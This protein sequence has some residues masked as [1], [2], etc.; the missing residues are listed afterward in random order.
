MEA[1]LANRQWCIDNRMY[2]ANLWGVGPSHGPADGGGTFYG[3]YGAPPDNLPFQKGIDNDGTISPSATLP[4]IVFAP[5]EVI[6]V[7]RF[8]YDTYKERFWK[9][10][11]FPDALNPAREWF[12]KEYIA[13]D[14]GPI[15]INIENYR[16]RLMY[17]LF[18]QEPIVWNGLRRAGFMGIVDNF[19]PSE[20][21]PAYGTW[22]ASGTG[23]LFRL[24][25]SRDRVKEGQHALKVRWTEPGPSSKPFLAVRPGRTDFSPYNFLTFWM[26]GDDGLKPA[27]LLQGG[28]PFPLKEVTRRNLA[29]GWNRL[30]FEIP[31]EARTATVKE[32][33]FL[34]TNASP[35]VCWLDGI[36]LTHE[37]PPSEPDFVID[38]FAVTRATWSSGSA[39]HAT[40]ATNASPSSASSLRIDYQKT[41][42]ADRDAIISVKPGITDWSRF[43]SVTMWARGSGTL[44]LRLADGAGRSF[45]VGTATLSAAKG[46]KMLFF[47]I[48]ANLNPDNCW[49]P[50]YDKRDI[51]EMQLMM[52]PGKTDCRGTVCLGPLLL[53]E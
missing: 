5:Q 6:R 28:K 21:S 38:D 15:V 1:T 41:G 2:D 50:R 7:A 25:K 8:I 32:L 19:N 34:L 11:G 45:D 10:Y 47:N 36:F 4:S 33:R 37:I 13:I 35:G 18:E 22:F 49:E 53:T 16:S 52:E 24:E 14:Q 30:Y 31:A 51:R 27:L 46:W 26:H 9:R 43:H 17:K 12:G 23:K 3:S 39:Y 40:L 20:H 44:R 48:Q 42:E 29:Q